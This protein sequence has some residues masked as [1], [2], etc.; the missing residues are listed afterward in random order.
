MLAL[1]EF[2]ARVGGEIDALG[3]YMRELTE[4]LDAFY[5]QHSSVQG[6]RD[7]VVTIAPG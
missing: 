3:A 2:E 1:Q 6:H 4:R 5:S 7:L